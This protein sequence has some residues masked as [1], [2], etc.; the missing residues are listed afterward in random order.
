MGRLRQ[1]TPASGTCRWLALQRP[2]QGTASY[3]G[4]CITAF[5]SAYMY[6]ELSNHPL[7][8]STRVMV[9]CIHDETECQPRKSRGGIWIWAVCSTSAV[10]ALGS[11]AEVQCFGAAFSSSKRAR[12]DCER[13]RSPCTHCRGWPRHLYRTTPP[14][15]VRAWHEAD[16]RRQRVPVLRSRSQRHKT[17]H[18]VVLQV[19][20]AVDRRME[21]K[22]SMAGMR[23]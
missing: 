10:A 9:M 3:R 14:R 23:T 8:G 21:V 4:T 17:P 11:A 16:A 18:R 6:I 12:R 2:A 7:V 22:I 13:M 20:A 1:S 15:S 5:A 19:V